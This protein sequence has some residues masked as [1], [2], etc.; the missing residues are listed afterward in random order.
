MASIL[1]QPQLV[2]LLDTETGI[3]Y[4]SQVDMTAADVPA[5]WVTGSSVAMVLTM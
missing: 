1:A 5:P 3:F 2:N 4:D